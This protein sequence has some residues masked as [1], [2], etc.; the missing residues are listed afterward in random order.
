MPR[1]TNVGPLACARAGDHAIAGQVVATA[2]VPVS[3]HAIATLRGP[4]SAPHATRLR[5]PEDGFRKPTVSPHARKVRA[6][7]RA[8]S[9]TANTP[10]AH[11]ALSGSS[12]I[13]A[14]SSAIATASPIAVVNG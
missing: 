10:A 14:P 7:V 13:A 12:P 8:A 11:A 2:R 4:M 5:I 3:R 9:A 1:V 6:I